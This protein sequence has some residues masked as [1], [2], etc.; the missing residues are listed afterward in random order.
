MERSIKYIKLK[1]LSSIIFLLIFA[2]P[3]HSQVFLPVIESDNTEQIELNDPVGKPY[4]GGSGY[5]PIIKPEESDIVITT[6]DFNSL[7]SAIEN[8]N[9]GDTIYIN[10]NLE[11]EIPAEGTLTIPNGVTLASGRGRDGSQGAL[12]YSNNLLTD[13]Y[14]EH[15]AIIAGDDVQIS[16]LRLRGPDGTSSSLNYGKQAAGIKQEYSKNLEVHNCEIYNW[17]VYGIYIVDSE[18]VNIH[19]N[20]IHNNQN[21]HIGYGVCNRN[22]TDT[23]ISYNIFNHNRHDV[24][25]IKN[26]NME[27]PSYTVQYNLIGPDAVSHRFD[28]HGCGYTDSW[29]CPDMYTKDNAGPENLAGETINILNNYLLPMNSPKYH[30]VVIRGI[31]RD[32]ANIIGNYFPND[33]NSAPDYPVRQT[34]MWGESVNSECKQID[35]S[36]EWNL[37]SPY[38]DT[39]PTANGE[40]VYNGI[41]QEEPNHINIVDNIIG[42]PIFIR[43]INWDIQS[44][45]QGWKVVGPEIKYSESDVSSFAYGD[46]NNDG[47]TDILYQN[48]ISWSGVTEWEA[49]TESYTTNSNHFVDFNG[50]AIEDEFNIVHP[51]T[52]WP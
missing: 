5:F 50:D 26:T 31:P 2:F 1:V 51:N 25:G 39:R 9:Y 7:K 19:H 6:N 14:F 46:F 34:L 15:P 22:K 4:G 45:S 40:C 23:I 47:R 35:T 41:L 17:Y 38:N 32:M 42:Y 8:A 49:V 37:V 18:N 36:Y 16:G 33:Y 52:I 30:S 12:L 13:P 24:A 3:L 21:P 11:I 28:M 20:Y 10:D 43:V 44:G 48:Y 29:G 27:P